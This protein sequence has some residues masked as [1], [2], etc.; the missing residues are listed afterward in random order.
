MLTP[1]HEPVPGGI[2][3]L[4]RRRDGNA[5]F[6]CEAIRADGVEMRSQKAA[7]LALRWVSTYL[8]SLSRTPEHATRPSPVKLLPLSRRAALPPHV[9]LAA[10]LGV[11]LIL[12]TAP[13]M[14]QTVYKVV[15][16]QGNVTFTDTPPS[17]AIAEEQSINATNTT[18]VPQWNGD[19]TSADSEAARAVDSQSFETRI[20]TPA[21]Q[22]TIPMGPGNFVVEVAVSPALGPGEN[23]ILTLDG[24]AVGAPQTGGSW[25]LTNVFRGE[26]RLQ[27]LRLD[28]DGT[29]QDASRE[30]IVYVMRPSVRN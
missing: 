23:L 13:T 16:E 11:L 22:A 12:A 14:A 25:Q 30:H 29:Q 3:L 19:I 10:C 4:R 17:G 28:A 24:A 21:D 15:D 27:V 1:I 6:W 26:H 2:S 20:T 9:I 7:V 18:P 8:N 5:P